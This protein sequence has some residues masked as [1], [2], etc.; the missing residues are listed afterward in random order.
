MCAKSAKRK[1]L[2]IDDDI[3]IAEMIKDG[4]E[5]KGYEVEIAT[6]GKDGIDK[7]FRCKP[8]IITLDLNMPGMT[9]FEILKKLKSDYSTK[10]IP[11]FILTVVD[12]KKSLNEAFLLGAKE[13]IVKPFSLMNLRSLIEDNYDENTSFNP[14][15]N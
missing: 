15:V 3:Y 9:G 8:S 12:E 2:V 13:Y 6:T 4:L 1:V 11:I 5:L 10:D 14:L 7:A